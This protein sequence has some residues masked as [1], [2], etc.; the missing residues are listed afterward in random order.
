MLFMMPFTKIAQMVPLYQICTNGFAPLNKRAARAQDKN[1]EILSLRLK[2]L[3]DHVSKFSFFLL[4]LRFSDLVML[5]LWIYL[6]TD[7]Q[8]EFQANIDSL[9]LTN[10]NGVT[11][12]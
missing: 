1:N 10:F 6:Q 8:W 12:Y 4:R 3:W 7:D 2:L 5:N 9:Y 11:Q